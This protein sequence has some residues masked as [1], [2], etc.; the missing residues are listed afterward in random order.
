ML[1]VQLPLPHI[2]YRLKRC[3]RYDGPSCLAPTATVGLHA[4]SESQR[5]PVSL[6]KHP[7]QTLPPVHKS[8]DTHSSSSAQSTCKRQAQSQCNTD[9]VSMSS[10]APLFCR[11]G[12]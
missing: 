9:G 12:F 1:G 7:R 3:S 8:I 11:G 6:P 4:V 5:G 2:Y 10:T